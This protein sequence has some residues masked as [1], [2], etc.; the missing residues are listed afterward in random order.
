MAA[1]TVVVTA[2]ATV[3]GAKGFGPQKPSF[4]GFFHA[5][6]QPARVP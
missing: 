1:V 3:T 5:S 4:E 2:A 6:Q